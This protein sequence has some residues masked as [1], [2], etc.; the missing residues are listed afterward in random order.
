MAA[1]L[2]LSKNWQL[3]QAQ[4]VMGCLLVR[5]GRSGARV[6]RARHYLP[7]DALNAVMLG[8]IAMASATAALFFL[9]FWRQTRDTLFLYFALAFGVDAVTRVALALGDISNEHEPLF[10]MG[11]LV[12]VALILV[13]IVNKNR[14]GP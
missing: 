5:A 6:S 9:R 7:S 12:T 10:Y 14:A 2:W 8:A 13:A 3:P 11:R 4:V 1:L